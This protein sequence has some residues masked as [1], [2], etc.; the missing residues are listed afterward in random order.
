MLGYILGSSRSDLTKLS[1]GC[2]RCPSIHVDGHAACLAFFA[3]WVDM[4]M[5]PMANVASK[6]G[7]GVHQADRS[8][9]YNRETL[10]KVARICRLIAGLNVNYH[11]VF[12]RAN[13]SSTKKI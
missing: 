3:S 13:S 12:V 9:F 6:Q 10:I 5:T 1:L 2:C 8:G 4:E 7:P 11:K